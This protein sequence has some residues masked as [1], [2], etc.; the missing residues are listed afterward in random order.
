MRIIEILNCDKHFGIG[1]KN[2]LLFHQPKDMAFFRQTTSGHV[3][4][5]GENTLLS[6]PG[7]KPLP[8]RLNIVLSQD[9][10]HEY[11]G[12]ENYHDMA[13][14]LKAIKYYSG[15]D[16]VYII[17]GASIYRQLL[18]F[19]TD[20]LLTKIDADGEAEVFFPNIDEDE[21]F[22]LK[23]ISAPEEDNGRAIRFCHYINKSPLPL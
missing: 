8:N 18:P 1:K 10:A 16:D 11:E 7:A 5:M 3:V 9:K 21:R 14:F 12:V 13:S 6:F 15:K 23:S 20:I 22:E 4:A 2:G 17:G 19:C